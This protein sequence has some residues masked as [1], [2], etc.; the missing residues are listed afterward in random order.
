MLLLFEFKFKKQCLRVNYFFIRLHR[1]LCI[2]S[3]TEQVHLRGTVF[4]NL[5]LFSCIALGCL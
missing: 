2:P 3:S 1:R 4:V 5:A